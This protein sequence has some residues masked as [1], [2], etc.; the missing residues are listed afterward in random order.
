VSFLHKRKVLRCRRQT[1]RIAN[2][3]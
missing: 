1:G 3:A 2:L